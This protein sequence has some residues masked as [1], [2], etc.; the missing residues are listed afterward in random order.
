MC[1]YTTSHLLLPLTTYHL[2]LY[3]LSHYVQLSPCTTSHPLLPLIIYYLTLHY[4]SRSIY[5]LPCTT[6]HPLLPL[7][8]HIYYI[9]LYYLSPSVASHHLLHNPLLPLT[10]CC[11]STSIT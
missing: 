7:A 1:V 9:T 4:L 5:L 3:Y 10:L 11:L 2:T 8:L 6:S